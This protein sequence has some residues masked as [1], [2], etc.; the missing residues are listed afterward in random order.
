MTNYVS[1]AFYSFKHTQQSQPQYSLHAH[2]P[3]RY[4]E[5]HHYAKGTDLSKHIKNKE[6]KNLQSVVV[7]LLYYE[8]A[9]DPTM[10]P[11]LNDISSQQS[12]PR[13]GIM[14]KHN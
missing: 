1:D 14:D 2:N 8:Q 5:K 12:H 3:I 13:Q 7:T 11:A 9:I 4:G 6:T 10:L